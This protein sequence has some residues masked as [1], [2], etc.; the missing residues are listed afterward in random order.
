MIKRTESEDSKMK[1]LCDY[2][3]TLAKDLGLIV[4]GKE[5]IYEPSVDMYKDKTMAQPG[6]FVFNEN[7]EIIY[8]MIGDGPHDRPY[9]ASLFPVLAK[10]AKSTQGPMP[11][12]TESDLK[13]IQTQK[14]GVVWAHLE[15][16][17][18]EGHS[19]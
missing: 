17:K 6:V 1:F 12:L 19:I 13:E 5:G 15:K 8:K 10:V 18:A 7:E 2:D 16:L 11:K 9:P 4:V 14:K 3:K